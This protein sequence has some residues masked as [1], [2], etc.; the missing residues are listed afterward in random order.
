MSTNLA[1][2]R[3]ATSSTEPAKRAARRLIV[4]ADYDTEDAYQALERRIAAESY[5][6]DLYVAHGRRVEGTPSSRVAGRDPMAWL[7]RQRASYD[8]AIFVKHPFV[9]PTEIE[10]ALARLADSDAPAFYLIPGLNDLLTLGFVGLAAYDLTK[11]T[12]K[13][14]PQP[15]GLRVRKTF[16]PHLPLTVRQ[17][18]KDMVTSLGLL[19]QFGIHE[20]R[21]LP[22]AQDSIAADGA[23]RISTQKSVAWVVDR[24]NPTNMPYVYSHGSRALQKRFFVDDVSRHFPMPR[25]IC[26]VLSNQCNLK[27]VM[28]PFHSPLFIQNRQNDY[29]DAKRWMPLSLVERLVDE[30]KDNDQPITFHMGELD[31]PLLHPDLATIV[32]LLASVPHSTVH[33][34][35]N[36]N[37]LNAELGRALIE[38]GIKSIQFSVDAQT[39]ATYKKIRGAKLEKVQRNVERFLRLR[40]ELRP[41]L[42]V[43]LCIINQEGASGEIEDFKAYWREKGASSVSVYQLFKPAEGNNAQWVVP[44]KYYEEK[45]RKPCTALW[46]QCFLHPE[47]DV[48]LCCTTLIRVPQDGVISKGNLNQNSLTDIWFGALYQKVR[49]DLI[50][51]RFDDHP[52]CRDCDNWSSSYQFKKTLPDGTNFIHGE[53]MGYYYFPEKEPK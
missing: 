35:S 39:P 44:N 34:T 26:L 28:C 14:E 5:S 4:V 46:D 16:A 40:D 24:E 23:V 43:N 12:L 6:S 22:A 19:P 29:F 30:L 42:Y 25:T 52:Y 41:G 20:D 31:E 32:K 38:N 51:E 3:F 2:D 37:L 27:C 21:P 45:T 11:P 17:A 18:I 8:C 53:S 33:I 13:L 49:S 36:G 47:G 48:S 10:E 15:L 1:V 7:A 50:D 9:G